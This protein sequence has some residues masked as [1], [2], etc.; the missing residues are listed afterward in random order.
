MKTTFKRIGAYIIDMFIILTI[1]TLFSKIEILNP[2]KEEYNEIMT[3]YKEVY[4]DYMAG[5]TEGNTNMEENITKLNDLSYKVSKYSVPTTII[6]I[7][8]SIVYFVLFAYL[9]KGQTIGKKILGIK[10]VDNKTG[11]NPSFIKVLLRGIILYGYV[12]SITSTLIL[13]LASK[14]TY[15]SSYTYLS[16]VETTLLLLSF[17]FILFRED[18]RGLHD[19]IAGT[20]V[21]NAKTIAEEIKEIK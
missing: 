12:T 7:F 8:V 9:N 16:F 3:E 20:K 14:S 1:V 2:S 10:V 4:N 18:T 5:I 21:V 17:A 19:L 13:A 15:L 6:N 11:K